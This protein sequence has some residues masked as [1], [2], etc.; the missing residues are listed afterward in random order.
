MHIFLLQWIATIVNVVRAGQRLE[1]TEPLTVCEVYDLHTHLH[2][3]FLI[4]ASVLFYLVLD[5]NC[6]SCSS[7]ICYWPKGGDAVGNHGPGGKY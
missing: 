4:L 5:L 1:C 7:V 6:T 2:T 3:L